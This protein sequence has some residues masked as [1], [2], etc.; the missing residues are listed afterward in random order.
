MQTYF[1]RKCK[2][3]RVASIVKLVARHPVHKSAPGAAFRALSVMTTTTT[4]TTSSSSSMSMSAAAACRGRIR[5]QATCCIPCY[6]Y[7][8][9]RMMSSSSASGITSE[10]AS[11]PGP[12]RESQSVSQSAPLAQSVSQSAPLAHSPMVSQEPHDLL[13][14]SYA[15]LSRFYGK[16]NILLMGPPGSGKTTVS[17][18]LAEQLRMQVI[19]VDNDFLEQEIW[20]VP[21]A[22]KLHE[23]GDDGFIQA[24]G[25]ALMKLDVEHKIIS[26]TG[27]NPLHCEAMQHVREN[28]IVVF[29]DVAKDDILD[30]MHKMKVNRVVGCD[31]TQGKTL[32]DVL[33][34]RNHVY[35]NSYDTRVLVRTGPHP[36]E[37]IAHAVQQCLENSQ[38]YVSTRGY[39]RQPESNDDGKHSTG[40]SH[41]ID[42][43]FRV[44]DR[45]L[46]PD[47]GLYVPLHF[48]TFE[49][50]ELER[51]LY[52]SYA[53]KALRVIE[54]FPLGLL[55]PRELRTML[56]KAYSTFHSEK[57][58]PVTVL[59]ESKRSYLMETFHGPT[60][61]FKD[62]SLQL[63][64]KLLTRAVETREDELDEDHSV[65]LSTGL[66]VATSGDTGCAALHGFGQEA[67]TPVIVLF[68]ETGVSP[69]QKAQMCTA[70]GDVHV[71][72]IDGDFDDCQ[73]IV[74][75]ILND[76]SERKALRQQ[77]KLTLSS[78]NSIN[79][80]RFLPQVV[81]G[82]SSYLQMIED[83]VIKLGERVDVCI[84]TG[85]FGNILA[86]YYA[87]QLGLPVDRLICASNE[88][89]VL[90]D[91]LQTGVY[92]L[93]NRAFHQTI[94]PSIDIL[95]SS[96]LERFVYLMYCDHFGSIDDAQLHAHDVI[97]QAQAATKQHFEQLLEEQ[98]FAV[99]GFI[100]ARIQQDF[101]PGWCSE[102]ECLETIRETF[103]RTGRLIDPHTAVAVK[104]ANETPRPDCN[105][106][107]LISSTAHYAKFP[108][109]MLNAL[110]HDVDDTCSIADTYEQL[111]EIGK[112]HP[113]NF[114]HP[115]L[116]ALTGKERVH[117][118]VVEPSA[119][120][121]MQSIRS[122]LE[123]RRV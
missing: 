103:D 30:R 108:H 36:A 54:R 34:F 82:F 89:N 70:E 88:N 26:L 117:R 40:C 95:V 52:L 16:S 22:D 11:E 53:E 68:P 33:D 25:D 102:S 32:G 28:G 107:M 91:F 47:R 38:E 79:W 111:Q 2:L 12:G 86:T 100:L 8:P 56:S 118:E 123:R 109:A 43:I 17:R 3:P 7:S 49:D 81:F 51:M 27:S 37:E 19:D 64:P 35:E 9:Y 73:R 24:E 78:G 15:N 23:L 92:D 72:G 20:K 87:K 31:A 6:S 104:V 50:A 94:S 10:S 84:P 45:G 13:R 76:E 44:I 41:Q 116:A 119:D 71:I 21:V 69:V 113:L 65:N 4:T 83:G 66:I 18:I 62:L 55:Q 14:S 115:D 77:H 96:N 57:V 48:T 122:F 97:T 98:H 90:T 61:S 63:T 60:A 112:D 101:V 29:L 58:L 39:H 85:N 93:R 120:A 74:K 114:I 121:V 110:G 75:Q 67:D 106:P 105:K 42:H 80:G 99:P 5:P 46:A 59:D 1:F